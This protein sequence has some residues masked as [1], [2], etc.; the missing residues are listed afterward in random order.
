MGKGALAGCEGWAETF[1]RL[2]A[3]LTRNDPR[4]VD[5]GWAEFKLSDRPLTLAYVRSPYE[6]NK[7]YFPGLSC[8]YFKSCGAGKCLTADL[9]ASYRFSR[10]IVEQRD[11]LSLDQRVRELLAYIFIDL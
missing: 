10:T 9:T 5:N 6:A 11:W 4:L 3:D 7:P 8:D 2:A 1:S